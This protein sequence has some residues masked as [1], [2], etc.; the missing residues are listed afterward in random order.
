MLVISPPKLLEEWEEDETVL[1]HHSTPVRR[2]RMATRPYYCCRPPLPLK[3]EELRWHSYV[4]L[5]RGRTPSL[6]TL[7]PRLSIGITIVVTF[8]LM[9]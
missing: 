7:G 8:L 3:L 9:F 6:A 4:L 2:G 5:L 1:P